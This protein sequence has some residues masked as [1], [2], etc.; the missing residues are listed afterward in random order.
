[1]KSLILAIIFS[2]LFA[3]NSEAQNIPNNI[4]QAFYSSFPQAGKVSWSNTDKLY[5]AEFNAAGEKQFAFFDQSG[6]IVAESRYID[7][8]NLSH[9]L[10]L[11]LIKQFPNYNIVEIFEVYSDLQ[12]DYYVTLE[13]NGIKF[14]LK[15]TENGKWKVFQDKK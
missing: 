8:T 10:R 11:G 5:K 15:S 7:F 14:I 9:R 2:S 3:E 1:M 6:A 12:T 4:S 13:R